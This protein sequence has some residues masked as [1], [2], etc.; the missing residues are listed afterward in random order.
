MHHRPTEAI[1]PA[2]AAPVEAAPVETAPETLAGGPPPAEPSA[3]AE[4]PAPVEPPA[5]AE[6]PAP[7]DEFKLRGEQP[8]PSSPEG[9]SSNDGT[10]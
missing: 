7:G 9:G 6:P 10:T 5:P 8:G 4:P 1:A 3:P 2:E